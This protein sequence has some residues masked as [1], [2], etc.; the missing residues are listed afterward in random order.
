[1]PRAAHKEIHAKWLQRWM[2]LQNLLH[3]D[4]YWLHMEFHDH[5]SCAEAVQGVIF[6]QHFGAPLLLLG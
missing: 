6:Y 1:M 2:D 5:S 3:G 4:G